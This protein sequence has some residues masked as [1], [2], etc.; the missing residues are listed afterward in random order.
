MHLKSPKT[1]WIIPKTLL[2]RPCVR[3]RLPYYFSRVITSTVGSSSPNSKIYL[4][5]F[6]YGER[7]FFFY[8]F[9]HAAYKYHMTIEPRLALNFPCNRDDWS[10]PPAS[11]LRGLGLMACTTMPSFLSVMTVPS[12]SGYLSVN[13]GSVLFLQLDIRSLE[14]GLHL[15]L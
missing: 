8:K 2:S 15:T 11:T 12:R 9:F 10:D 13:I 1:P 7:E 3:V 5:V 6:F 4:E 14:Q